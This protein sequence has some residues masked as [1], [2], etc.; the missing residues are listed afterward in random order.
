M[1]KKPLFLIIAAMTFAL[2]ACSQTDLV[3]QKA[4]ESFNELT[5]HIEQNIVSGED[6]YH[7][8][9]PDQTETLL[10]GENISLL[11]DAKPFTD[12]GLKLDELPD[13]IKVV[14]NQLIISSKYQKSIDSSL[15]AAFED[16]IWSN[17]KQLSYH[18]NHDIFELSID[19]G[20]SFKWAKEIENSEKDMVFSLDP[21]PFIQAGLDT[22]KLEGWG[23]TTLDKM[24]AGGKITQVDKLLRIYNI[25]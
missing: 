9:S 23:L 22:D 14:D 13:S 10:L 20:H 4:I 7:I 12:A 25:K 18:T 2:S 24:E 1:K 19:G 17:R 21:E 8:I 3:A 11:I 16:C 5:F 15:S 6:G